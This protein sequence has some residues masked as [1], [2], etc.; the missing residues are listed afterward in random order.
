MSD[1]ISAEQVKE[2]RERTGAGVM[3]C[4]RALED[5]EGDSERA[6]ALLQERGA[7]MAEKRMDRE[8]SQG[9]IECYIHAG[10]RIGSMV[11]LNCETDFVARTDDFKN[12]AHELAMQIA[13]TNPLAVSE[14]DLPTG[15]EGDPAE[16]CLLRQPY[17]RDAAR[18]IDELVREVIAKT[19][20]NVRVRRFSRF[21][22][23]Q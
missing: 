20:E 5:A 9:A 16:L 14:E 21:E 8:T 12:L 1:K 11:E 23:G 18:T 17:I 6:V 10:G 4:K 7:A 13:A 15:A 3:D 2:L 22:L 19:G